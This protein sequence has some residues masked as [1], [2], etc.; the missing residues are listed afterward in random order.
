[1]VTNEENGPFL[2]HRQGES[3]IR[4]RGTF[5][6][7]LKEGQELDV[8]VCVPKGWNPLEEAG[9][10]VPGSETGQCDRCGQDI[11]VAPSTQELMNDYPN[12]PIRC[13]DCVKKQLGEQK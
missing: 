11:W 2:E 6:S 8:I 12:V 10:I 1:M 5:I 4:V 9:V 7:F 3:G 13:L